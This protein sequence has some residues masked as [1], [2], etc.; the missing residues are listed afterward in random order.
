MAGRDRSYGHNMGGNENDASAGACRLACQERATADTDSRLLR[1]RA[2]H[3]LLSEETSLL[4][5]DS[6]PQPSSRSQHE[7]TAGAIL[8]SFGTMGYR[9]PGRRQSSGLPVSAVAV[10]LRRFCDAFT[11]CRPA[12]PADTPDR[13]P[14]RRLHLRPA[15]AG[16]PAPRGRRSRCGGPCRA[17]PE[18]TGRPACRR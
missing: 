11:V 7:T 1:S 16:R 12:S 2:H 4:H 14:S 13:P 18:S 15:D 9:F 10:L 6:L 17:G 3:P 8:S 5:V